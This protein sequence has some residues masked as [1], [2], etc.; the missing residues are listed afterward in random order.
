[1]APESLADHVYT[2]KTDVWS[3]G[4][5]GWELI[6]L[7]ATPYPGVSPQNLYHL[8]RSGYRM[9]RPDN[10]SE[11]IYSLLQSCWTDDPLQRPSFKILSR[12]FERL[13]GLS[14]KYLEVDDSSVSNPVYLANIGKNYDKTNANHKI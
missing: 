8:L 11:E 12:K 6:T 4:I 14:A 7:G 2:T 3:F 9:E 5:V 1:M 13:L 10:C